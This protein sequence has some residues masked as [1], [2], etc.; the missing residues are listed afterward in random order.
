MTTHSDRALK[1]GCGRGSALQL[2][3]VWSEA[4]KPLTVLWL[5]TDAESGV[6]ATSGDPVSTSVEDLIESSGLFQAR[7]E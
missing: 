1:M 2:S 3:L 7:S 4:L 5:C 6:Y